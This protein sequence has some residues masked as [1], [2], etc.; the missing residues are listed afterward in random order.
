MRNIFIIFLLL[1]INLLQ[2]QAPQ[3]FSFQGISLTASGQPIKDKDI[4]VQIK[5]LQG[6]IA[7]TQV[8]REFHKVRTN[9][10]GIYTISVGKGTVQNGLFSKIDW[11]AGPYALSVGIDES[12]GSTFTLA[13]VSELLSVPY[14]LYAENA[15]VKPRIVVFRP[16]TINIPLIQ[17]GGIGNI[18]FDYFCEWIQG[19]PEDVMIDYIGLPTNLQSFTLG[20]GGYG[21]EKEIINSSNVDTII[22]GVAIP[23]TNFRIKDPSTKIPVGN[24]P[25]KMIFRTKT[26]KLDSINTNLLVLNTN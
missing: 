20:R 19:E 4:A 18:G 13:G 7:G 12:G 1:C 26:E 23:S 24:Y 5:I 15:K 9:A 16:P 22:M 21:Y 2:A 11:K 3:A 17:N 25:I 10:N 14:A 8:Y 6:G